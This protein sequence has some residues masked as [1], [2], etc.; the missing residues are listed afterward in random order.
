MIEVLNKIVADR[1]VETNENSG[2]DFTAI[3]TGNY[4]KIDKGSITEKILSF[5]KLR[6]NS[7]PTLI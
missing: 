1:K 5:S 4:F 7:I 2:K 3:K 6:Q